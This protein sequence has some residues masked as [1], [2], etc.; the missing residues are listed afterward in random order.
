MFGLATKGRKS[1]DT[2]PGLPPLDCLV[3]VFD[4]LF[5]FSVATMH[6][7]SQSCC[8]GNQCSSSCSR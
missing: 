2:G 1:P 5:I 3:F 6:D 4:F 8:V 7:G